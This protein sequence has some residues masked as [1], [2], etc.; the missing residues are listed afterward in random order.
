M[1]PGLTSPGATIHDEVKSCYVCY[2]TCCDM[3]VTNCVLLGAN[4]MCS[5]LSSFGATIH[6][7]VRVVT[8]VTSL[9]FTA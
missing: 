4:I 5:G 3:I 9:N 8:S 7:E 2:T 1:C 6:D